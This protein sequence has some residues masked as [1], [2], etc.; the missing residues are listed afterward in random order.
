MMKAFSQKLRQIRESK[1][2]SQA[3][4]A[5]ELG[6]APSSYNIY[7]RGRSEIGDSEPSFTNLLKIADILKVPLN[8]LLDNDY[9]EFE[10]YK[11][12]C[13]NAGFIIECTNN[14]NDEVITIKN[15]N[16]ITA[17]PIVFPSKKQF[18]DFIKRIEDNSKAF[19][20][21]IFSDLLKVNISSF[22]T[23]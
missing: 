8:D 6:I 14:L 9:D 4:I 22:K 17:Q 3:Y 16:D 15:K 11:F 13:D 12:L 19:S 20:K 2:I 23:T 1:G 21:V 7:E 5:R 18:I 10:R